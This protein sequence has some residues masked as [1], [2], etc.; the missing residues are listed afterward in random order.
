MLP[1]AY[2]PILLC[3]VLNFGLALL[4][5]TFEPE[6]SHSSSNLFKHGPIPCHSIQLR[7]YVLSSPDPYQSLRLVRCPTCC[8]RLSYKIARVSTPRSCDNKP[9]PSIFWSDLTL[10]RSKLPKEVDRPDR[11]RILPPEKVSVVRTGFIPIG[12]GS[13]L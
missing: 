8:H 3:E 5:S 9:H 2:L 6:V 12:S 13:Y 7:L 4:P 10:S 11:D 1:L